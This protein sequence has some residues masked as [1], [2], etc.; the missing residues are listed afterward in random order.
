MTDDDDALLFLQKWRS[1]ED[2]E[3]FIR[4]ENFR[5]ILAAMDLASQS[6]EFN[7]S[8]VS[9]TEGMN[10]IEKLRLSPQTS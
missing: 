2:F 8:T 10:L 6:P 3:T 4:S 9:S 1:C 7:V 5:R